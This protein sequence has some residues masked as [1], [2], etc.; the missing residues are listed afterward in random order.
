M[1]YAKSCMQNLLA[2]EECLRTKA[3]KCE[4]TNKCNFFKV[5]NFEET[6]YR[7]KYQPP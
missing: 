3:F 1:K 2:S 7:I 5:L 6:N 4:H